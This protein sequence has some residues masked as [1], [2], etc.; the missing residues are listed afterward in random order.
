MTCQAEFSAKLASNLAGYRAFVSPLRIEACRLVHYCGMD[1]PNAVD[2][3][4]ADVEAEITGCLAEG[5]YVGWLEDDGCLYIYVQEPG[6][7]LPE[8]HQVL[9][10]T[11]MTDVDGILRDQGLGPNS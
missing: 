3:P 6:C 11:A 8:R 9:S 5:F 7:P 4:L 1:A 2:V 10:E